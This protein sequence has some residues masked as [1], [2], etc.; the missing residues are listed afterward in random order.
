MF[1]SYKT[2]HRQFLTNAWQPISL[3]IEQRMCLGTFS[4][5]RRSLATSTLYAT[6]CILA[7]RFLLYR[8][9]ISCNAKS[10]LNWQLFLYPVFLYQILL[11][12]FMSNK[13]ALSNISTTP[14]GSCHCYR[15]QT[16]EYRQ[17]DDS[18]CKISCKVCRNH[19]LYWFT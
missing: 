16:L 14:D 18:N 8:K 11:I 19:P 13:L 4:R 15:Q 1:L 7:E 6:V 10:C 2:C 17:C 9:T 3:A 12:I 5:L